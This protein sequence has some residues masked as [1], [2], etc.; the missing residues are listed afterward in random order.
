MSLKR[1]ALIK[2]MVAKNHSKPQSVIDVI[3]FFD[4]ARILQSKLSVAD[5]IN[6]QLIQKI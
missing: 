6:S 5:S 3:P 1:F 2:M 4:S